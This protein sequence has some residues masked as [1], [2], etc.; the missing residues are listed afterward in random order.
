[1][2]P[3]KATQH[4]SS[5]LIF[6][7]TA[8]IAHLAATV[9]SPN[10]SLRTY[11]L[12][13]LLL[14]LML[15]IHISTAAQELNARLDKGWAELKNCSACKIPPFSFCFPHFF[16]SILFPLSPSIL[17][18]SQ[19]LSLLGDLEGSEHFSFLAQSSRA[20]SSGWIPKT[21]NYA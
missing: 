19:F 9:G 6:W 5:S 16:P 8:T 13:A 17:L 14:S 1:M 15:D 12:V 7:P 20:R 21:C 11:P 18:C 4:H 10:I 2:Y 3:P